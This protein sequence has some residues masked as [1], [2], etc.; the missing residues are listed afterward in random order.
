MD[1][2]SNIKHTPL[3]VDLDGSLIASDTLWEGLAALLMQKPL[4]I[5]Q[6]IGWLLAGKAVLKKNVAAFI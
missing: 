6:V 1:A 2:K 4:M 3:C 5:F